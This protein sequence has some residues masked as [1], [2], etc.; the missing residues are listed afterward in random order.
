MLFSEPFATLSTFDKTATIALFLTMAMILCIAIVA[1]LVKKRKPD[2]MKTFTNTVTGII[3]G[4]SIGIVSLLL[5]LK[6]DAY[7][8]KGYIE[9]S[10]FIPIVIL[11]ITTIVLALIGL[12]ISIFKEEKFKTFSKVAIF[13][14]FIFIATL[15]IINMVQSGGSIDKKDAVWLYIFTV[16]IALSIAFITFLVGKK[17]DVDNT[18]SIVYASVCIAMSFALSYLRFFELPQG[19]SVTFASL[20][21]L[22]VYTY[23]FGVRKG[24]L[25]CIIYGFLQFIQAPWFMHPMQFL[26]DYPIAFGAIGLTAIFKERNIFNNKKV[27]Q[28]V[29]GATVAVVFRYLAHVVS[30]IF[31]FGSGDPNYG[32]VAWSFLYNLFA[33][34][35]LAIDLI[36]GVAMFASTSFLRLIDTEK[37]K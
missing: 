21:P 17:Q 2:S 14:V 26:L 19:G 20:L 33:F 22:M 11:L 16:L 35:D 25:A 18:K 31:V 10:T 9:K 15:L 4:Y 13:I 6:L 34:A 32:A 1:L 37:L 8:T 28:F 12:I 3:V 23:M 36:A 30:G 27:L 5:F 24:V 29:F 7:I